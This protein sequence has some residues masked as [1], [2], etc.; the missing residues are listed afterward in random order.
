MKKVL[1]FLMIFMCFFAFISCSPSI[2]DLPI[3]SAIEGKSEEEINN[4]LKGY[5]K[6][7]LM[8]KWG[9]PTY[10]LPSENAEIWAYSDGF[11]TI[12]VYFTDNDRFDRAVV[13]GDEMPPI[14]GMPDITE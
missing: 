5:S 1:V 13:H 14:T 12:T 8:D 7:A 2:D 11:R 3:L 4:I 9:F 6:N 10:G